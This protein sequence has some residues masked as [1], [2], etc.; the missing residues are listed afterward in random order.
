MT[1]DYPDSQ[2]LPRAAVRKIARN[3]SWRESQIP[4]PANPFSAKVMPRVG[5]DL[6]AAEFEPRPANL[7]R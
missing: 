4:I 5:G 6:V 3:L 2:A 1:T 7:A